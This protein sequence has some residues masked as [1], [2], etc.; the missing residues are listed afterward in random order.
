MNI[1][2]RKCRAGKHRCWSQFS[3]LLISFLLA[4]C[5]GVFLPFLPNLVFLFFLLLVCAAYAVKDIRLLPVVA[6]IVGLYFFSSS[7]FPQ[8]NMEQQRFVVKV[9][10][11]SL[12]DSFNDEVNRENKISQPSNLPNWR[13]RNVIV[14][15]FKCDHQFK[16][17]ERWL[18]PI[19]VK[20][21][22]GS[23]SWGGF[24]YERWV[25]SNSLVAK[26]VVLSGSEPI[27]LSRPDWID[28]KRID[29][30]DVIET[31]PIHQYTKAV[32]AALSIGDRSFFDAKVWHF[33]KSTG[34]GRVPAQVLSAILALKV[35]FLYCSLAGFS[36]PTQRAFIMLTL[37]C[38][39]RFCVRE[40]S[41]EKALLYA[42]TII[43][44][45]DPGALL[46]LSL[47][48]SVIAVLIILL[49]LNAKPRLPVLSIQ[50]NLSIGMAMTSML[51]IGSSSLIS[52]LANIIVVH[53]LSW[54][55]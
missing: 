28:Q 7:N 23:A 21:I 50:L 22:H 18:L 17:G 46:S 45:F 13:G 37:F 35:T 14:S 41:R 27:R 29:I 55:S 4:C 36:I 19:R 20:I 43:I 39:I 48:M 5:L 25:L 1:I 49:I 38:L 9:E 6:F 51:M 33:F 34:L 30:R 44:I 15:C 10:A 3:I 2:D 47:W 52:P 8:T 54:L 26:A 40:L 42:F 32:L 12:A 24:D 31:A 16:L 11:L 53:K